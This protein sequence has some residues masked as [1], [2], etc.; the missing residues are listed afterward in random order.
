MI[1]GNGD[2]RITDFGIAGGSAPKSGSDPDLDTLS[3]AG[4]PQ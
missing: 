3:F 1:D 2:V 4:T